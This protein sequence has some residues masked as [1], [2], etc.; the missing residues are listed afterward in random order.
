MIS[1]PG[2]QLRLRR[3]LANVDAFPDK[4]SAEQ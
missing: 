2:S 3:V 4:E 1:Q